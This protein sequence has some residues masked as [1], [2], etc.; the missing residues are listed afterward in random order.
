MKIRRVKPSPILQKKLRVAA[1]ARVS[2]DTL[3]HSL[4]AQVSYYSALIQKNPAWE[5]AGVYADEGIS[6]TNT[7]KRDGF[8]QMIEDAPTGKSILIIT[9]SV[10]RFAWNTVDSLQDVRKLDNVGM[11]EERDKVEQELRVLAE[12]LETLIRKNAR[13]AQDQTAYLKQENEIR[14]RYL[15]KQG[16]LEK[17]DEQIT[18]RERKR[19]T[20]EGMIHVICGINGEQVEF[21]EELWGG[22]LDHIV[23]KEDGAVV[24]IFKGG[25]EITVDG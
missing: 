5:Y 18:E 8:N 10:S 2:V 12:R 4:A 14:T 7:K 19:N 25:I 23:V 16:D 24:V 3:H 21:D 22:L 11:T 1:Y 17:L 15:E 20:L 9:K 6:G 13:V